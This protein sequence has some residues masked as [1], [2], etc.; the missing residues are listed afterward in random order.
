[1]TAD[2]GWAAQFSF[3]RK[4]YPRRARVRLVEAIPPGVSGSLVRALEARARPRD[5]DLRNAIPRVREILVQTHALSEPALFAMPPVPPTLG[6][7]GF[8][9]PPVKF[10][11]LT[12]VALDV[13]SGLVFTRNRGGNVAGTGQRAGSL[14]G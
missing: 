4:E 12:G 5:L 8:W 2:N 11:H 7:D 1:M 3:W 13:N 6:E 14:R 9:F 10:Q